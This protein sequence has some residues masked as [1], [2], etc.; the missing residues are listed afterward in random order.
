MK[1]VTSAHSRLLAPLVLAALMAVG[2]CNT[3]SQFPVISSLADPAI[4]DAAMMTTAPSDGHY[5]LYEDSVGTPYGRAV[6]KAGDPI[7]FKLD[8]VDAGRPQAPKGAVSAVA[9]DFVA[10]LKPGHSYEWRKVPHSSK[11]EREERENFIIPQP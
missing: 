6:L 11:M 9:G 1:L 2:G 4:T 3:K 7:G 8:A 10:Q 5:L